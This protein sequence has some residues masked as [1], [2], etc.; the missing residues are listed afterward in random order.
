MEAEGI[1]QG[2]IEFVILG[3]HIPT[4][5]AWLV[6][7]FILFLWARKISTSA[8]DVDL[9]VILKLFDHFDSAAHLRI[10]MRHEPGGHFRFPLG[11]IDFD[12]IR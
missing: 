10:A 6:E 1:L 11:V 2:K 7:R 5:V 9:D 3:G 12:L 4:L 8:V